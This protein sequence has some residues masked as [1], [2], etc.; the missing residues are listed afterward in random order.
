MVQNH[1]FG[2]CANLMSITIP[3][4]LRVIRKAFEYCKSLNSVVFQDPCGWAYKL[5]N[6]DYEPIDEAIL[7]DPKAA[8]EFIKGTGRK[9]ILRKKAV[10]K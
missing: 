9:S 3:K 5:K 10:K 1:A 7:S 8:A 2:H 6:K 4:S